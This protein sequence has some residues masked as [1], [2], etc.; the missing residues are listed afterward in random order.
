[1][2]KKL[3][4]C[5]LG[6]WHKRNIIMG[7]ITDGAGESII[8]ASVVEVGTTNGTITDFDRTSSLTINYL[9]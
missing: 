8:G 4:I 9:L 3:F 2:V 7:V 1:M 6:P 5:L